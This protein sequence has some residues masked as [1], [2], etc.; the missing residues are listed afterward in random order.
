MNVPRMTPLLIQITLS[1]LRLI[2]SV[3]LILRLWPLFEPQ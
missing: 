2:L 1:A 3:F